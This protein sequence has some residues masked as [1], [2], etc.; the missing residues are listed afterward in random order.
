MAITAAGIQ[1]I[2]EL[3]E[4]GMTNAS[5]ARKIGSSPNHVGQYRRLKKR[6]DAGE[7]PEDVKESTSYSKR[8]WI[9][10]ANTFGTKEDNKRV[11]DPSPETIRKAY[12]LVRGYPRMFDYFKDKHMELSTINGKH[13]AT[14]S[15]DDLAWLCM[16]DYDKKEAEK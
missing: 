8:T 11:V 9:E 10:W 2:I 13:M 15:L 16:K 1:Q 14:V 12:T 4:K 3:G 7:K 6:Y 5:I